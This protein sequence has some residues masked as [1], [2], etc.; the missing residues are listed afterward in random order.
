MLPLPHHQKNKKK[1]IKKQGRKQSLCIILCSVR[2]ANALFLHTF[3]SPLS[4]GPS[5]SSRAGKVLE[6]ADSELGSGKEL[7]RDGL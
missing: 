6:S 4:P 2:S 7:L 3:P 1:K 5:S